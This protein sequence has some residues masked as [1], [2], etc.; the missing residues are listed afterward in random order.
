MTHQKLIRDIKACLVTR[1]RERIT[2]LE[3]I[4]QQFQV[5]LFCVDDRKR[6]E[7]RKIA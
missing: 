4:T 7:T 2:K 5:Y 1:K 6:T 3:E